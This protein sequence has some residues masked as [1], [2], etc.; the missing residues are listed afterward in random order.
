MIPI[1]Y[2]H[3]FA[4]F[5]V[6]Y[7]VGHSV[8]SKSTREWLW[9]LDVPPARW[10]VM[11]VECPA[12]FGFWIGLAAGFAGVFDFASV[13]LPFLTPLLAACYTAATNLI[14]GR[15]AGIVQEVKD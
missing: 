12:C 15:L 10:L 1:I 8:A 11:L 4:A 9:D 7:L 2:V 13:P 3:T 6:A 14:L 5:G